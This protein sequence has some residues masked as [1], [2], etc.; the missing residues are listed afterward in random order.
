LSID[1]WIM[2]VFGHATHFV[3]LAAVAGFLVLSRAVISKRTMGFAAA[4]ALF[5]LSVLMKQNGIFFLCLGAAIAA[6]SDIQRVPRNFRGALF[7]SAVLA[8][9]SA[10]PFAILFFVLL[11]QGTLGRFWFWTFQYAKEY[12][13]RV[14]LSEAWGF[15][16][17]AVVEITTANALIW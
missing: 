16:A 4:G 5:G 8:A 15:F 3:V 1:R 14:S 13:S 7:N 9:G 10:V 2:G 17:D 12:V 6:W 11:V